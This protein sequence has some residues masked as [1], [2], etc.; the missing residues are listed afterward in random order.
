MYE[1]MYMGLYLWLCCWSAGR[2]A[3]SSS[4]CDSEALQ[5]YSYELAQEELLACDGVIDTRNCDLKQLVHSLLAA[6]AS[7]QQQQQLHVHAA[8]DHVHAGQTQP[9]AGAP[10]LHCSILI[11]YSYFDLS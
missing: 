5:A 10:L 6:A 11:E 8:L 3:S 1:Y 4:A 2:T 7:Q 9:Y